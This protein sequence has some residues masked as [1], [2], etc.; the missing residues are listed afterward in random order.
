MAYISFS[1]HVELL[2]PL[3]TNKLKIYSSLVGATS[4]LLHKLAS[5]SV[6]WRTHPQPQEAPT[7]Y[8]YV[9]CC[10]CSSSGHSETWFITSCNWILLTIDPRFFFSPP[11][12]TGS[13]AALF[14]WARQRGTAHHSHCHAVRSKAVHQQWRVEAVCW[15]Q[16]KPTNREHQVKL[17]VKTYTSL[18]TTKKS[19][20]ITIIKHTEVLDDAGQLQTN[21]FLRS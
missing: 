14:V 19:L 10:F 6:G 3:S 1:F 13:G 4:S 12:R 21:S 16:G 5:T 11:N 8:L 2:A 7:Q 9:V 17:M 20:W 18:L 15:R